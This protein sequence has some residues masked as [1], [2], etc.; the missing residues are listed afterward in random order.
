MK[1]FSIITVCLNTENQIIGTIAS[2]LEQTCTNFEYIIKD[3][4]SK[5]RTVSIA[6]SFSAAFAER[7]IGFR[8]ISQK[9]KGIYDAMNQAAQEAQGE[10]V[11]YMNAG[12]QFADRYVLSMVEQH[13]GLEAADIVYGD[14]V[15]VADEGYLY[16][17]AHPLE[18]MRD[19]LPFCHQS[20]FARKRLYDQL[21]Y[22]LQYQLC[23]DYVFFFQWYREGKR[24][25]YLPIAISLYDRHGISSNGKSVVQELLQI[26]EDMPVRDEQTIQ[27]L[28]NEVA[29]YD[30]RSPLHRRIL[31]K[32]IPKPIRQ[33]R[34][35]R[36]QKAIG[37]MTKEEFCAEKEKNGGRVNREIR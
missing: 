2:V 36:H 26:H 7:G 32:M 4:G 25:V 21:P 20:V 35:E 3:G 15:D 30:K 22:S 10:W 28:K 34:W 17:K 27:M 6:Q 19:R 29:S 23:S 14:R 8:V 31:S 16:R 13:G 1:K 5:D 33:K 24:F 11:L 18:R 12:D 9:D 37:W